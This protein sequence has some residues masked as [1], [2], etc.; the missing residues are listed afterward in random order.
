MRRMIL[1]VV[2]SVLLAGFTGAAA[3]LPPEIMV[4]SYLLRA[5]QALRDGDLARAQSV[6][7]DILALQREHKLDLPAEFHFKYAQVA[8]SAGLNEATIDSVN[9]YLAAAGRTGEFYREALELLDEAEQ[10]LPENV[11]GPISA[12]GGTADC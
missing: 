11:A 10:N 3:Q 1:G 2:V 4:D 6:I 9:E 5:E 8:F 12:A 7:Q